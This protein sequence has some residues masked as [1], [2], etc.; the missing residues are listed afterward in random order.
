[1]A[2]AAIIDK[3]VTEFLQGVFGRH[4]TS[5]AKE[6]LAD[7]FVDHSL[8]PGMDT[9]RDGFVAYVQT[10]LTAFPDLSVTVDDVIVSGDRVATRTTYR[11]TNTGPLQMPDGTVLP[12]TGKSVQFEGNDIARVDDEG[13]AVEHWGIFDQMGMMGQ[14]GL[15]P[16]PPA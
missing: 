6:F 10:F 8:P 2:D 5:A 13:H 7:E 16:P 14:L 11:G 1:M 9:S 12:A 4:D 3:N 15:L